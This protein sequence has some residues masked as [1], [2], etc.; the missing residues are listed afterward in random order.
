M[1]LVVDLEDENMC[2]E[3]KSG[4]TSSE[5]LWWC[6]LTVLDDPEASVSSHSGAQMM[7]E[8]FQ[9]LFYKIRKQRPGN[10]KA[11]LTAQF[12]EPRAK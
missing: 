2:W 1:R 6:A 7:L 10:V 4:E 11:E 12:A 3:W 9:S 8:I 5:L